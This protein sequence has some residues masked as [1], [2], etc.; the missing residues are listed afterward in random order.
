MN[1]GV[2]QSEKGGCSVVWW[3]SRV[4]SVELSRRQQGERTVACVGTVFKYCLGSVLNLHLMTNAPFP[5]SRTVQF[6]RHAFICIS[7]VRS[8]GL[9]QNNRSVASCLLAPSCW[10]TQHSDPAPKGWS[11]THCSPL[12]V[13]RQKTVCKG[14]RRTINTSIHH[15]F[16]YFQA[17]M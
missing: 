12:T 14:R 8:C 2:S 5:T 4:R 10:G 16:M 13:S 11:Q 15:F 3:Y 6:A 17:K 1:R 7:T 9:Y